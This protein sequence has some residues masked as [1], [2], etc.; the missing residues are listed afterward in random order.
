MGDRLENNN[1]LIAKCPYFGNCGGCSAQHIPYELQLANSQKILSTLLKVEKDSIEIFSDSAYNYRNRMD[2]IVHAGGL[3]LRKK[4]QWNKIVD[5]ESCS[6]AM[7]KVNELLCEVREFLLGLS[8]GIDYFDLEKQTGSMKYCVIRCTKLGNSSV[9]FCL[10]QDS[11]TLKGA[12]ET[13][14][15]YAAQSSA[16]NVIISYQ[17][18]EK[19][20]SI[21][22]E[23][24]V[25][26]GSDMLFEKLDDWKY[27]YSVQGFFQNNP[28]MAE[29]MVLYVKNIFSKYTDTKN[30]QLLDLYGGVGTFGVALADLFEK[31]YVMELFAP[32][33]EIANK[34]IYVNALSN[35]TAHVGDVKQFR[36]KLS[37]LISQEGNKQFRKL[38]FDANQKTYVLVDPP[39]SGIVPKALQRLIEL[40]PPVIVYISCN[41]KQ[42]A[43]D[44]VKLRSKGYV[45]KSCALFDL[46]PQT[47]HMEAVVELVMVE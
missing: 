5:I 41:P 39:R 47:P 12:I 43:K 26:K 27:Y 19:D 33:I 9:S 35:V 18:K 40:E 4:G 23:Y 34:N 17:P 22:L 25:C 37:K 32:S 42:L 30:S 14:K 7:P 44:L 13:V 29:K 2:F 3:G 15:L 24:F 16:A 31:V 45:V 11:S 10:N 6:I 20:Q 46:F 36:A 1:N 21:S 38:G 8:D 28:V